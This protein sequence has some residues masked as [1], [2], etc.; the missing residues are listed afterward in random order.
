MVKKQV[1]SLIPSLTLDRLGLTADLDLSTKL[2]YWMEHTLCGRESCTDPSLIHTSIEISIGYVFPPTLFHF[3]CY[4]WAI[5]REAA[6]T[7]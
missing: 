1:G 6:T 5:S 4:L 2:Y 3:D 7:V